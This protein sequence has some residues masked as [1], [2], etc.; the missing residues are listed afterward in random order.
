MRPDRR[1]SQTDPFIMKY[2][3]QFW[4]GQEICYTINLD[5]I[6]KRVSHSVCLI[7]VN[8]HN[9]CSFSYERGQFFTDNIIFPNSSAKNIVIEK[10]KKLENK[11]LLKTIKILPRKYFPYR[12][13]SRVIN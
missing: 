10:R 5:E 8:L 1:H 12:I 9:Q 11:R 7:K 13:L 4:R 3:V 6:I 2:L